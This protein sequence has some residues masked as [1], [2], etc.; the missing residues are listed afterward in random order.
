MDCLADPVFDIVELIFFA[1]DFDFVPLRADVNEIDAGVPGLPLAI[2]R[3][4]MLVTLIES[5]KK[6]AGFLREAAAELGLSNVTVL[7]ERAEDVGQSRRRESFDIVVAR[8]VAELVW[9]AEWCLPL[10]K[11]GGAMLAMKGERAAA[12]LPAATAA[13]RRLGG[14]APLVYPVTLPGTQHHVIVE[15]HKRRATELRY[16]R[17]ATLAKGKPLR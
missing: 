2:V 17:P 5:T 8:A 16:P 14:D 6:K 7:A 9:L 13:A 3:P 10:A 4:E 1:A 15:L 12:E 11:I